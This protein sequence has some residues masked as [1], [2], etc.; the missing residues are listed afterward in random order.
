MA[1]SSSKR[2]TT[3]TPTK[4]KPAQPALV[5]TAAEAVAEPVAETAVEPVAAPVVEEKP[6]PK[7]IKPKATSTDL[8]WVRVVGKTPVIINGRKHYPNE[9]LQVA[10]AQYIQAKN[11]YGKSLAVRY[12]RNAPYKVE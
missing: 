2:K 4:D 1:T 11:V 10:Y 12:S 9:T 7:P 3:P 6:T 8:V 5:E